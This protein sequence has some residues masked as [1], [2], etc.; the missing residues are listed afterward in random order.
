[1]TNR[2]TPTWFETY[3]KTYADVFT[4]AELAF[5]TRHL[6]LPAY[7]SVLDL[8]CGNGRLALPLAARGY[9]VL[10]L[11][12]DTAMVAEA[13]ARAGGR[14][15]FVQGDMRELD[16]VPGR[17]D[18]VI[19]MWQSFGYFDA[20]TNISILR[21]IHARLN[22]RGRFIIDLYNRDWFARHLGSETVERDG[23]RITT[24]RSMRG[25]RLAVEISYGPDVPMD[26][27]DWQLYTAD[28]FCALVGQIGFRPLLQCAWAD[29]AH[30]VTPAD[31]R[32]Q[33]VF[34]KA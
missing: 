19:N 21:Q 15:H 27:F 29:D 6:P 18:A 4:D 14:A 31:G 33:L 5:L 30:P 22:P 7:R 25:D 13:S 1:V 9:A 26:S 32:M 3:L 12:R 24:T 23:R 8:C 10:G 34:E 16:V 20:E 28:E 2:F 17:F 11:E